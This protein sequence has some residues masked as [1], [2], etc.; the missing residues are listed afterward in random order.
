[1]LPAG[2]P[3]GMPAVSVPLLHQEEPQKVAAKIINILSSCIVFVGSEF[4]KCSARWFWFGVSPAVVRQGLE[5]P[6]QKPGAAGG[7]PCSSLPL[8]AGSGLLQGVS[9]CGRV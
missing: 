5:L 7:C 4:R 2:L 1:M 9:L 8:H 3:C 6:D